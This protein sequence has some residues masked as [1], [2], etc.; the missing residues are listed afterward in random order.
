M[1]SLNA[2]LQKELHNEVPDAVL[3]QCPEADR[4][5]VENVLR[6]AQVEL[7]VLN[8]ASTT[9]ALEGRK[10]VL[11]CALTGPSPCVSLS[12][13]RSLQA[14]SPARIVEVK[15]VVHDGNMLIVLEIT[16]PNTRI[17]TTELEIVRITKRRRLLDRVFPA[18]SS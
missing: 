9:V 2:M 15:A 11:K 13:M 1:A 10:M 17:S 16:D 18:G 6:L 8:L 7:V 14:Y 3:R 5:L 12:S 4:V